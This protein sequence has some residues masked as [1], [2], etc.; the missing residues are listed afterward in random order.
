MQ[1]IVK[2]RGKKN[3][4]VSVIQSLTTNIDKV[5][6]P[7]KLPS[8]LILHL[9]KKKDTLKSDDAFS[10]KSI[11]EYNPSLTTP[12]AY[13]P[14]EKSNIQY[15]NII[16]TSVDKERSRNTKTKNNNCLC[17]WCFHK[18]DSKTIKMPVSKN[19]DNSKYNCI[20]NFC[21]PECVC[22]YIIDSGDRFGDSWTQFEL[23][24]EMIQVNETIQPAPQ[25]E[26]LTEFGGEL[27][28][29]QFRS[30]TQYNLNYPPM[31]SLKME[32][33][34][35]PIVSA[36]TIKNDENC[37]M[38]NNINSMKVDKLNWED[39]DKFIPDKKKK[40]TNKKSQNGSL[41]RFWSSE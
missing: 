28:I 11:L 26:L 10:E 31:V 20:G 30:K 34:D 16:E 17:W 40:E 22:A 12:T 35:T 37:I 32:M 38:F 39:I 19:S 33:D 27:T 4:K 25:R 2:K 18:Y 36:P 1:Q 3:A 24:H 13:D 6:T 8:N 5:A 14:N 23:L 41:D 21:S 15:C 7:D 9:R 29:E